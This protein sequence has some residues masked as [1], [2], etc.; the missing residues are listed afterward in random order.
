MHRRFAKA[1]LV[2]LTK[3]LAR[4]FASKGITANVLAPGFVETDMIEALP[5]A[6]RD[7]AAKQIPVRRFG[8]PEEIAHA[9]AFLASEGA[10]YVTGQV[11]VVDGGLL[12]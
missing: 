12:T 9:V 1:G 4:E 3:T 8:K 7:E 10:A 5:E 11:M 6:Q 2:G